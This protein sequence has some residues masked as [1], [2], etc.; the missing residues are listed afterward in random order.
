M[1]R[2]GLKQCHMQVLF[3]IEQQSFGSGLT[4]AMTQPPGQYNNHWE[5]A[6]STRHG[7]A[8]DVEQEYT[9]LKSQIGTS[10]MARQ[11]FTGRLT[12]TPY[13]FHALLGNY[14]IACMFSL[15]DD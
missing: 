6:A 15:Q 7:M 11:R 3:V 2:I 8:Q 14:E 5:T 13:P 4:H 10:Q 9:P 1:R 12:T